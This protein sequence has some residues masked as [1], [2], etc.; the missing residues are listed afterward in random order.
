LPR[1][2]KFAEY[3]LPGVEVPLEELQPLEGAPSL[4]R[5]TRD[6]DGKSVA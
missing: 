2:R 1:A 3:E 4:L 6:S 5:D